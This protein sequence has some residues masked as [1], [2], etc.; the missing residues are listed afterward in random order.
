MTPPTPPPALLD[1]GTAPAT[2]EALIR[3]LAAL[4]IRTRTVEHPPVFTVEEARRYKGD[5]PGA[6]T[7]NLFLR[8]KPGKRMWLVCVMADRDVDLRALPPRIGAKPRLSF[9]SA[10][11]LMRYLGVTPGA[12]SPFAILNDRGGRVQVVLDPVLLAADV[13]NLHPL[14]NAKTTAIA[15]TDLLRFLDAESHPPLLLAFGPEG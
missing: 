2:T 10:D 4:G 9:G 7:K 15:P 11:R 13:V 5:L 8:D 14:D 12:V 1:D 6:H 3:R